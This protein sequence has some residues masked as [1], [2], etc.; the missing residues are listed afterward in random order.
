MTVGVAIRGWTVAVGFTIDGLLEGTGNEYGALIAL[1]E[2]NLS[3]GKPSNLQ[4]K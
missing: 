2:E 1:D 4:K 3:K